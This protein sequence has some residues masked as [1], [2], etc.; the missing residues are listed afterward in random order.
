MLFDET[1]AFETRMI[2]KGV[3]PATVSLIHEKERDIILSSNR[4]VGEA[5][6]YIARPDLP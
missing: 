2:E 3:G 1:V 4:A 5:V 6:T